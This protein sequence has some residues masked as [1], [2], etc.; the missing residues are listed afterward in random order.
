MSHILPMIKSKTTTCESIQ[1][2]VKDLI[3]QIRA[4]KV[5]S[6]DDLLFILNHIDHTSLPY[7]Y[8][9]AYEAKLPFYGNKVFL[10]ALIEISNYCQKGCYYCGISRYNNAVNRYRLCE[11][12]ILESC[13]T[14]YELGYRTFV[15]QA[16]E[17][18]KLTESFITQ[19]IMKIKQ[20]F[21]DSRVTLSLGEHSKATYQK[22]F[23]A[24]ADRYLL[25]HETASKSLYEMI[26]SK[27]MSF[28]LRRQCLADLKDIG[29]Q[30]GAGFMVGLPGQRNKDLVKDLQYL[31]RLN[32]HMIGIG[33]YIC[34]NQ[35]KL[36][37]NPDGTLTETLVMLALVRLMLPKVLLPSTTALGSVHKTGREEGLLAGA[38]VFMPNVGPTE[39][40]KDYEIYQNK[41]CVN[42]TISTCYLCVQ[43]RIKHY[44][45]VADFGVGDH[46]D[47]ERR[48]YYDR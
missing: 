47:V 12:D 38:N 25:R 6:S 28:D 11:N 5:L 27:D 34:H 45:H 19:L 17:D 29:Y 48:G 30:V 20:K 18:P 15:L 41:I 8:N 7:L 10:R 35:T 1:T 46:I 40:K 32:P 44:Q 23:N 2:R 39:F 4:N 26:H 42:D 36:K 43:G 14:A 33:P 24:G 16:G 22:W 21:S 31:K 13:K 9:Q 37:N 3:L